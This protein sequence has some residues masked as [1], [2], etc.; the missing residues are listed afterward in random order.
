[1][2]RFYE[3]GIRFPQEALGVITHI[4]KISEKQEKNYVTYTWKVKVLLKMPFDYSKYPFDVRDIKIELMYPD[5]ESG[6]L[7][8]PDVDGYSSIMANTVAGINK[9]IFMNDSKLLSTQFSFNMVDYNER[10]GN[11]KFTGL[12]Q[13]P[14]MK[15]S[16][17]SKRRLLNVL[18][19]NIIPIIV[20]ASMVFLIFYSITKDKDDKSGVSMMGVVQSSAGFFFV[21]LVAHIDLRR[22]LN[23]SSLTYIESLYLTM[24]VMLA[25]L[26]INV[27]TFT[28]RKSE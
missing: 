27:V 9:E 26:A 3:A 2:S 24:Y 4:D 21:L 8:V 19:M 15:Y 22:R 14:I 1:M 20:V 13:F 23:T 28:K 12:N 17:N 11:K 16:I 25:I 18:V 7:L 10:S 5:P 6:I